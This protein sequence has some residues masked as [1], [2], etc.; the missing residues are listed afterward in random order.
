[1][2]M[3]TIKES[4][5]DIQ[6]D[7]QTKERLLAQL[8]EP[9][10]Q[11][12]KSNFIPI[13]SS[14]LA[15][16]FLFMIILLPNSGN[17]FLEQN[18]GSS[19]DTP[20]ISPNKNQLTLDSLPA[21]LTIE[22]LI[23][24]GFYINV[25]D[26]EYNRKVLQQFLRNVENKTDCSIRLAFVTIEGDPILIEVFYDKEEVKIF[27]DSTRDQFGERDITSYTYKQIGIFNDSLYAYND[28][29]NEESIN[30]NETYYIAEIK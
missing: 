5:D 23:D 17:R 21:D 2:I 3:K 4:Y 12:K 13:V 16:S 22:Q 7:Q 9:Q 8:L 27:H 25:H 30:H 26:K 29:L 1:M 20:K 19:V 6:L 15:V 18:I 24:Y 14:L 11:K 10:P 28:E